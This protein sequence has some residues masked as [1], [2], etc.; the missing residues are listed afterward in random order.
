MVETSVGK[1]GGML[2]ASVSPVV[3]HRKP[4]TENRKLILTADDFGLSPALNSA[5]A[6]AHRQGLLTGASFMVAAPAA[7]HALAL[8]QQLPDL[9]LG[10]HLTLA[11]GRAILPRR[12]IPRL[13][14]ATG[15]FPDDPVAAGWRYYFQPQLLPE[16][17]RELAAQID[18]AL[19]TGL[20][21][22][23][24]NG[25][26]NLHLHPRI[27]PIV[28][29]L[30]REHRIPALRLCRE[31]WRTT[32]SLAPDH[33]LP[34]L[35]LGLI[36]T[37]LSRQGRR[38]AEAAGLVFNDHLFGLTHDGRMTEEHLLGLIPR[39]QPGVTEIYCHPALWSDPELARWGPAYRRR[40]EFIAL[41]SPR[42]QNL[43]LLHNVELSDFRRLAAKSKHFST[44]ENHAAS[45]R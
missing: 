42:L 20:R 35:A 24:L 43:L 44:P 37:W 12:H 34:K 6:L 39:L 18:A 11:Q 30:A 26:L 10:L 16:I 15:N 25:H 22:W 31:D 7:A 29:D 14:D 28:V 38:L 32:L 23:F 19:N 2:W 45:G 21:F 3:N 9:C 40:E 4:K 17:R 8:A 41:M 36:F 1:G 5:V 27:L 33:P 13:V